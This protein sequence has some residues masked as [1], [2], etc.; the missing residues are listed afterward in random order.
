M[1]PPLHPDIAAMG[2]LL[3]TWSGTGRGEYPTIASFE[4]EET[5]TF[6]HVGKPFLA[7]S[8]GTRHL[9]E[10]RPLHAESGYWRMPS[11]GRVEMVLAHPTGIVEVEEGTW[12]NNV[13]T[14]HTTAVAGSS[15]AKQVSSLTRV[16][17]LELSADMSSVPDR[18]SYTVAM[19]AVGVPETHHLAATL[20]RV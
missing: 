17:T 14:L 5:I 19:G 16:F 4:Y 6:G 1:V 20:T 11:P 7:Y 8:Q 18:L 10:G 15:T 3:G 2:V 13:I 12:E 9:T